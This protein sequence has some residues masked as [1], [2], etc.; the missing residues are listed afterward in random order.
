MQ[1]LP[2][3]EQEFINIRHMNGLYVDKTFFAY[4]LL[5]SN[6]YY[7]L[8]RPRRFGK[9]LFVNTLKEIFLGNKHL[10]EGLYIYDKIEWKTYPV[11][12]LDFSSFDYRNAGLDNA[13]KIALKNVAN[14][15]EITLERETLG[16]Q[17]KELIEKLHAKTGEQVVILV[18]EYDKPITEYLENGKKATEQRDILKSFY[19]IIKGTSAHIRFFFLTGISRFSKVSV[20]SDLNN[21]TDLTFHDEYHDIC[22]YT[23]HELDSCFAEYL[24][25]AALKNEMS[26]EALKDKIKEWYNGYSWN[27]KRRV[28][29][30]YSILRF[31]GDCTFK[32]YWFA[33][34]TPTFLIKLLRP[35]F[36]FNLQNTPLSSASFDN[37]KVEK[38]EPISLLFQ[39]GYLTVKSISPTDSYI[40]DYPNREVENSMM[41]YLLTDYARKSDSGIIY[42]N[43]VSSVQNNDLEL[44]ID[45]LNILFSS[46]PS[47]LFIKK[48]ESY[49][50]SILFI[51]LKL[52]GFYI[53]AEV[54]QAVG[55]LDAVLGYENRI[56]VM[57]FKL[58]ESA[59]AALAQIHRK[60]YA[61]AYLKQGKEIYLV[62]INF[63]STL[64]KVEEWKVE[65][66]NPTFLP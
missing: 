11:I 34:G 66:I 50:H 25:K 43:I 42:D 63:S 20:F 46:I 18:D 40:L 32:N 36:R 60:N 19:S 53:S 45:T 29:N 7:F 28:Y 48:K 6:K 59:D 61:S 8:S 55:R 65:K 24:E 44:F 12:Y 2:T 5:I 23:P 31:F 35:D 41:Q 64:K 21:L 17:F 10:F 33:T 14:R 47:H 26:L 62:G 27:G 49:Y 16:L 37:Y 9:S 52:A 38:L 22:G 4:Q 58:D 39:T 56:Y 1:R 54:N 30:P 13:I 15:Y 57:E 51:A 3:G